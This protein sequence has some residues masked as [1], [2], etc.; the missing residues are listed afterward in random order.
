[1]ADGGGHAGGP[2]ERAGAGDPLRQRREEEMG[3]EL[4]LH[5]PLRLR[6][7]RPLLGHLGLQDVLRRQALALLGEGRSGPRPEVPAQADRSPGH[8]PLP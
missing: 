5:G 4:G 2:P 7:R 3:C 6:C 8:H 1:M